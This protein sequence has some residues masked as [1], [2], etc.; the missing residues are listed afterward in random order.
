MPALFSSCTAACISWREE[1]KIN[2]SNR[3]R[4]WGLAATQQPISY[5]ST[6]AGPRSCT[7]TN[8]GPARPANPWWLQGKHVPQPL[9]AVGLRVSDSVLASGCVHV[10]WVQLGDTL[11]AGG[12]LFSPL[13][14]QYLHAVPGPGQSSRYYEEK[15]A[16]K[17]QGW[18]H[19]KTKRNGPLN[20]PI[21]NQA[22]SQF[23]VMWDNGCPF[24]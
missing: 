1:P 17:C 7:G 18:Q 24:L 8:P 12:A 3:C 5:F 23:L 20:E 15:Q 13:W 10:S 4:F 16:G 2:R 6:L 22:T 21:G 14:W 9:W 19:G 11:A